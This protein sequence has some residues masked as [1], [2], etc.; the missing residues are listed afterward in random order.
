MDPI[1]NVGQRAPDFSLKDLDGVPHRL[2]DVLGRIVIINFWSA[3]CP[4]SEKIDEK[5]AELL[6]ITTGE[7]LLWSIASNVN[8]PIDM[9]MSGAE[10]RGLPV[11]LRDQDHAVADLYGA[12][13][14]PHF[15]L[16]DPEG[17]LQ[18][19]G[20]FDDATFRQPEATQDYLGEALQAVQESRQPDP[21]ETPGYG[22]TIIRFT[23]GD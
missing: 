15:Y 13:T 16:I 18:Y 19:K 2:E 4:W 7:V 6:S 11:V 10:A 3:V 23:D 17:I 14:T 20:A 9:L 1:A 21:M 5:L 12:V 8:E 22:C